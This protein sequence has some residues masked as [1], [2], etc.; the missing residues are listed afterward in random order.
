MLRK[1]VFTGIIVLLMT[2]CLTGCFWMDVYRGIFLE[3]KDNKEGIRQELAE[4]Q[5]GFFEEVNE[6]LAPYAT[7]FITGDES[8]KGKRQE[9]ADDYA[10]SYE[11]DYDGFTGDEYIFGGT[12]MKRMSGNDLKARYSLSIQSGS[13]VLCWMDGEEEHVIADMSASDTYE[14][15]IHAG[16]NFIVLKGKDFTGKLSLEVE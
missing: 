1:C 14:F 13:A 16:K 7:H 5:D 10:G 3:I 12:L 4:L 15:T 8:L 11:A 2:V 9:G 6:W